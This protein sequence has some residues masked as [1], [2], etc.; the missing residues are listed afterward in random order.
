MGSNLWWAPHGVQQVVPSTSD[1]M[2]AALVLSFSTGSTGSVSAGA[3]PIFTT[4]VRSLVLL[5]E[6]PLPVEYLLIFSGGD[7]RF[8][9][10]GVGPW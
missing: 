6:L 7:V 2:D 5:T 3:I 4:A 1:H 10:R 9:C 8:C